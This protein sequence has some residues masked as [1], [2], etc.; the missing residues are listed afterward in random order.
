MQT[1]EAN[2][3]IGIAAGRVVA[4]GVA[5]KLARRE[6]FAAQTGAATGLLACILFAAAAQPHK[7]QGKR[8]T[9]GGLRAK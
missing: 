1:M 4:K 7:A 9:C 5:L 3:G 2:R 8:R 6:G